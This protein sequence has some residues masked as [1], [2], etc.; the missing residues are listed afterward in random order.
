MKSNRYIRR[1]S[2]L[3]A[4]RGD[5]VKRYSKNEKP[6]VYAV[7]SRH[8]AGQAV[9]LMERIK[10]DG[11]SFY[12]SEQ[13]AKR[14]TKRM[15]AA[16]S[17]IVFISEQAIRD[18][19]V[20][21]SIEY[22]VKFN[23]NILCIYLEPAR[24][25]PGLELLLNALQSIDRGRFPDEEAFVEKLTSAEVFA[26]M[27]IT[28]AQR[29][30][31]K[32]RGLVSVVV[33]VT[34]AVVIF[35]TV[36][37]PLLVV[38]MARAA[39]GSLSR[40]GYGDLSLADLAKVEKLYVVG[41]KSFDREYYAAYI[42]E[43]KSEVIG[44]HGQ[45]PAGDIRNISDLSLLKNART[46]AF[47]ANE[48]SDI[49]P[50]YKIKSLESLT[51]N[52]NPVRSLEGI[53]TLENL[54]DV[55]IAYT[56]ISDISPLFQIPSLEYISLRNT[57]VNSLEGIGNLPHLFSL[58]MGFSNIT[59]LSP[60]NEID[61]SYLNDTEGLSLDMEHL[62]IADYSPLRRVPKFCTVGLTVRR[63]DAVLPYISDKQVID[64]CIENNDIGTMQLLSSIQGMQKLTLL[65]A[66]AL[67]SLDG[68]EAH[69]GLVYIRLSNCPKIADY[70][71]LLDLPN[72][73]RL[74]ITSNMK[75]LASAQLADAAFDVIYEDEEM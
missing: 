12:Y 44:H 34:V 53:E 51:V 36:V 32:R 35:L 65:N 6:F 55:N 50:L 30:F 23:K 70:S 7:F 58:S 37:V 41:T 22:A 14:E 4:F 49:S 8:D 62:H 61:F 21:R 57:Y 38:P 46:I 1:L 72:L 48:V 24:L 71:P 29:R 60:L 74:E 69:D 40:V 64:L 73:E 18:E 63:L 66:Y 17:C 52:C 5:L 75:H 42:D 13:F 9:S 3:A 59:D 54:R 31:A 10:E 11:V 67:T 28:S 16:Y 2:R 27:E 15:E 20:K 19:T 33:P 47:E 68:I 43:T 39:N 25:S 56:G 26:D 45:Y